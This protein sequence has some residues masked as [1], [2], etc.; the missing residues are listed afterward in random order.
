MYLKDME[1]LAASHNKKGHNSGTVIGILLKFE[2]C[3]HIVV[4]IIV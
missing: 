4:N 2:L 3:L 1:D